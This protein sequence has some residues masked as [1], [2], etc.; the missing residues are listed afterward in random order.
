MIYD[1][2]FSHIPYVTHH[3]LTVSPAIGLYLSLS[4]KHTQF[5]QTCNTVI[6]DRIRPKLDRDVENTIEMMNGIENVLIIQW[7]IV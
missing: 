2:L 7:D 1:E 6:Q 4:M 5:L 3:L